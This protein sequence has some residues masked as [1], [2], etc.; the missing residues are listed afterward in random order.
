MKTSSTHV[1]KETAKKNVAAWN[2][3]NGVFTIALADARYTSIMSLA[4]LFIE[5]RDKHGNPS[6]SLPNLLEE[7]AA[8]YEVDL[9]E[10]EII[11]KRLRSNQTIGT[12]KILRNQYLAHADKNPEVVEMSD[13]MLEDLISLTKHIVAFA[14]RHILHYDIDD[15]QYQHNATSSSNVENDV[16]WSVEALF[17]R[18]EE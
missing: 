2:R 11:R 17:N 14:E 9:V 1:G 15:S 18:L 16:K 4:V 7:A 10:L 3:Y 13:V 5:G 12:L 8:N 6:M